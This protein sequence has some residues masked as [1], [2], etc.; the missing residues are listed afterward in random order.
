M[1]NIPPSE[2]KA[3]PLEEYEMLLFHWND[4]HGGGDDVAPPDHDK[5]QKLIDR[6]NADPK[7]Y[8]GKAKPN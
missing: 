3:L 1:M 7:L 4:A 5:T 2:A 8:A 6:I